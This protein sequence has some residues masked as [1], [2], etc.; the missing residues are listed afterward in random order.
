MKK[1]VLFLCGRNRLRSPT[2]ER[3]FAER[4]DLEVMSA[5]I[6]P[7]AALPVS[8][9]LIEWAEV[10]FVMEPRQR[11]KVLGEFRPYLK[12][13]RVICLD[14]P[15]EYDYMAPELIRLLER[16]VGPSVR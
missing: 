5:G 1:R 8:P 12:G 15:D 14:I 7:D 10:I 3:V 6:N 9:D 16:R 2:A 4:P 11:A 13:K